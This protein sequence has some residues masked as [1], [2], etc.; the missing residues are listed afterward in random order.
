MIPRI[1]LTGGPSGGKTTAV[2]YI[3]TELPKHG[4]TPIIVPELATLLFNSGIKWLDM[5]SSELQYH[6]QANMIRQQI[7]NE[8]MFFSFAYLAPRKKVMICD[9]GTI[10]NMVYA[11]DEWH[12]DILSQIGSLGYLKRR[13]DGIIHLNTLAYGDGYA[14]DNPA[15]YE[16]REQ[17]VKIDE[18]TFDMWR[19]GP[20]IFH[21]RIEHHEA[22]EN[23]LEQVLKY[24][25]Q[26]VEKYA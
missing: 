3:Q 26:L 24:I 2:K 19:K 20:E 9:R 12:E 7:V 6:F 21:V 17:A 18:R 5:K 25:L 11:K 23:K 8:D 4:V 16:T 22:L 14:L 13:Y 15:R 1:V 10:D